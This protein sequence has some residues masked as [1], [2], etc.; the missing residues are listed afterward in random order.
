MTVHYQSA[1]N[2]CDKRIC[3]QWSLCQRVTGTNS[4]YL[5]PLSLPLEWQPVSSYS[6]SPGDDQCCDKH[7]KNLPHAVIPGCRLVSTVHALRNNEIFVFCIYLAYFVIQYKQPMYNQV[8]IILLHKKSCKDHTH[9]VNTD[10]LGYILANDQLCDIW[11]QI[12]W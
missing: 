12:I 7:G 2:V 1:G 8:Y 5:Q 3:K 4:V 9:W 11:R 6:S 10:T